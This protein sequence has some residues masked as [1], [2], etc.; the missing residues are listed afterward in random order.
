MSRLKSIPS[1]TPGLQQ[2]IHALLAREAWLTNRAAALKNADERSRV[3][4]NSVVNAPADQTPANWNAVT[5]ARY[6]TEARWKRRQKWEDIHELNSDVPI[7]DDLP[8]QH[9]AVELAQC[10]ATRDPVGNAN[11]AMELG[12]LVVSRRD[13]LETVR[14]LLANLPRALPAQEPNVAHSEDF[15]SVSWFG[16]NYCFNISQ[17]LVVKRLWE[18]WAKGTPDVGNETLLQAIDELVPPERVDTVFRS[19]PAWNSMIVSGETKGTRRLSPPEAP[20]KSPP[21]Q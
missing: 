19:H 14:F 12:D 6:E 3:D 7:D 16:Q 8:W 5:P 1:S 20:P 18:A 21:A 11:V 13:E 2:L 17:A 15:R 10:L 4:G 9:W